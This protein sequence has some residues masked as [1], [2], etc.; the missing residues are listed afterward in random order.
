MNAHPATHPSAETLRAFGLGMVDDTAAREVK[1]HLES[2]PDC[3]KKAAAS[4]SD[5]SSRPR[6]A[7]GQDTT[8]PFGVPGVPPGL[9][10]NQ[11]HHVIRELGRGGMGIV[12]LARNNLMDR[13]EVLKIVNKQLLY[14]PGA[15]ERFLREIRSAA[16]LSHPNIVT[17]YSAFQA[18]E[19]LVF[20]ME[21]VEGETLAQ[22]VKA[23]GP[24]PVANAC[25]Y[26]HQVALGLQHAF[27]KGMVHR[28]IKPQNLILAR[29]NKKHVVKILDFG[30]AKATREGEEADRGLTGTGAMLGTPDYIA[31]EQTLDAAK[32][33]IRADIYSLG[34]TLYYLLAGTPPFK[35]NSRFELLQAHHMKDAVPLNQIRA[36]VP[37]DLAAVTARMMAK[38]QAKRPQQPVE[39]ARAL[40]RFA[41]PS[42]KPSIS[43]SPVVVPGG[44]P[45][46]QGTVIEGS[47]II[48]RALIEAKRA[49]VPPAA[50][51]AMPNPGTVM[52]GGDTISRASMA[53]ERDPTASQV[54]SGRKA[55]ETSLKGPKPS[56][57]FP[58]KSNAST[59]ISVAVG[60]VV[61]L[62]LLFGGLLIALAPSGEGKVT[63]DKSKDYSDQSPRD[64]PSK[65]RGK[66]SEEADKP[67]DSAKPKDGYDSAKPKNGDKKEAKDDK[68]KDRGKPTAEKTD[69]FPRRA[70]AISVNNY[71]F[72]NPINY[73]IPLANAHNVRTLLDRFTIGLKIRRDQIF[74]LSDAAMDK[75]HAPMK[76][77]MEWTIADFLS[78]SRPQDRI[79]LLLICH[80]VEIGD[81]VYLAPLEGDLSAKET[82]IPLSWLYDKLAACP[83]R[84]KIVILDTC[85]LNPA[86][87]MERPAASR[88]APSSM[89]SSSHRPRASRSGAPASPASSPM[90]SRAAI[91][92]TACSSSA[93]SRPWPRASRGKFSGPNSPSR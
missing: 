48:Q 34:C 22:F 50:A 54:R 92:I 93:C 25:Y 69:A 41:K 78:Q 88:W 10:A 14:H 42:T 39:V 85:R 74:E 36:D 79:V 87:G 31:P 9:A 35:A 83:A 75:A 20:A 62:G 51:P 2:C 28:D 38:D 57:R 13:P 65:D 77:V 71:L 90:S 59:V 37:A 44:S 15:A 23:H 76:D 40:A 21:Y 60:G 7:Q 70:L 16:K 61:L 5:F 6:A 86:R 66:P 68:A 53:A 29:E 24:L 67:K 72:A 32:A 33:D 45:A 49:D 89:P 73:G 91:S 80:S 8:V 82:L 3:H 58:K 63:S 46:V 55:P 1:S 30:L 47:A 12:Y 27:E 84:Q 26:V 52:E 4:S 81:E 11:Q 17:A 18:G 43:A 19:L 56:A 64:S